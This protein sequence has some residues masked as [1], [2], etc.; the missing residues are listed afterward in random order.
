MM[1]VKKV[2]GMGVGIDSGFL[3]GGIGVSLGG[4]FI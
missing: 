3:L 1:I 2:Y 4:L